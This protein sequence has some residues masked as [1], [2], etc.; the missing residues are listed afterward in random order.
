MER[1][2]NIDIVFRVSPT[3]AAVV[4]K[5]SERERVHNPTASD[6]K[7]KAAVQ[8]KGGRGGGH[9]LDGLRT[10]VVFSY[11]HTFFLLFF[12]FFCFSNYVYDKI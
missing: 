8:Q 1:L 11:H 12:D 4:V 10:K 7:S 9:R 6:S 5:V 3:N 2:D